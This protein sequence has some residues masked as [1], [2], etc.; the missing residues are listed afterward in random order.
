MPGRFDAAIIGAGTA[1][2]SV[3]DGLR[4]AK[5]RLDTGHGSLQTENVQSAILQ[6]TGLSARRHRVKEGH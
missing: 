3:L 5:V 1:G 2:L 6:G 4:A